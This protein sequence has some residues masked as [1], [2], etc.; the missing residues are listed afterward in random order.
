MS[1]IQKMFRILFHMMSSLCPG[2]MWIENLIRE[3]QEEEEDDDYVKRK[4]F[5]TN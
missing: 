1:I 4:P 5:Y 3:L 2:H